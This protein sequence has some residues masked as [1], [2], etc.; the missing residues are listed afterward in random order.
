MDLWINRDFH[1]VVVEKRGNKRQLCCFAH[2][3]YC[4]FDVLVAVRVIGSLSPYYIIQ[5]KRPI[6]SLNKRNLSDARPPEVRS[7]FYFKALERY[8]ICISKCLY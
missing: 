4:F 3:T 5:K 6:R 7:F 1:V 2:K 8:E